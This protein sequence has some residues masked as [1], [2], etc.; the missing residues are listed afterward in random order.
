MATL[1]DMHPEIA[2]EF[3]AGHFTAQRI[4]R[5]FPAIVLDQ[6]HEH[7]NACIKGDGGQLV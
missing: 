3:N 7:V 4:S 2:N 5:L 1:S 6:A